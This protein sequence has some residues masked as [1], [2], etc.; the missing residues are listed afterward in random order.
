M[1]LPVVIEPATDRQGFTARLVAPLQLSA[2]GDTA[3]EARRQLA[4]LLQ[5]QLRDGLLVSS[6]NVPTTPTSEPVA[7]WL[8]DDELTRDWLEE[9][10]QFRAE[11]DAA[12]RARIGDDPAFGESAS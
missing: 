12:D 6:L 4:L 3:E 1:E 7:G 2:V 11:C 9:V 5:Q 8:P 10:K